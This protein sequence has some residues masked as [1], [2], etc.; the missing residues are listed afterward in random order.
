MADSDGDNTV[1][2]R[3]NPRGEHSPMLTELLEVIETDPAI[4][5]VTDL[6]KVNEALEIAKL[7]PPTATT[8]LLR[9]PSLLT[10]RDALP[11]IETNPVPFF[12]AKSS[13]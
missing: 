3:S 7:S 13:M 5:K 10:P 12:G 8:T 6:D 4:I 1:F 11:G 9:K 2:E